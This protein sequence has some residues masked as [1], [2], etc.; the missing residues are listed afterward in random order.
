MTNCPYCRTVSYS[1]RHQYNLQY[2][3]YTASYSVFKPSV[4]STF[5][6]EPGSHYFC[7]TLI[8][9]INTKLSFAQNLRTS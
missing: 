5:G 1:F 4:L 7:N 9:Y 8:F 3:I 2:V 6:E